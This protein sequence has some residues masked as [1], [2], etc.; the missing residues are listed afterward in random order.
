MK[1]YSDYEREY[2][3]LMA[4]AEAQPEKAYIIKKALFIGVHFLDDHGI[5]PWK[6]EA[7]EQLKAALMEY[8]STEERRL[9]LQAIERCMFITR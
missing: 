4:E 7:A 3:E 5:D 9:F 8:P 6:P 2:A 1:N